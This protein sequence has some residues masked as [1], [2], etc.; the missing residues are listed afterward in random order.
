MDDP[1]EQGQVLDSA[2]LAELRTRLLAEQE[3]LQRLMAA[4][5]TDGGAESPSDPLL[6]DPEDFGEMAQDI[7]SLDTNQALSEN[8]RRLLEQVQ[9]ALRRMDAGTYGRSE[10]TGRPIPL[11]RLQALPWAT[12]NVDDPQRS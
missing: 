8:D 1:Q 12:T 10:V 11:E 2:S 6:S 3:R 4:L 7:T 5:S 9:N